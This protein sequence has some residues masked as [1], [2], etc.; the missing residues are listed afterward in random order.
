[1]SIC[2]RCENSDHENCIGAP[3]V[4]E[5][6]YLNCCCNAIDCSNCLRQHCETD[7]CH[8]FGCQCRE[9]L[10]VAEIDAHDPLR[11]GPPDGRPCPACS[12]DTYD[13]RGCGQY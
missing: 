2:E 1:M 11:K 10:L 12:S 13:C 8:E 9:C 7:D 5:G 4:L 6:G 3:T